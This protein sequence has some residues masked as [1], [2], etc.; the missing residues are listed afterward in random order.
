MAYIPLD[1][2]VGDIVFAYYADEECVRRLQ[3]FEIWAESSTAKKYADGEWGV[4]YHC[5]TFGKDQVPSVFTADQ[6]HTSALMAFPNTTAADPATAEE[7]T[8]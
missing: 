2:G 5:Q 6:L 4:M 7:V 3:V 1:H 8:A